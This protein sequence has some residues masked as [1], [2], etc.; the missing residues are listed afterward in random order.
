MY[1][2]HVI[3]YPGLTI[4]YQ[5]CCIFC[6][7][8]LRRRAD[9]QRSGALFYTSLYT[10]TGK[11]L[12][13][14]L[15][16]WANQQRHESLA[17]QGFRRFRGKITCTLRMC[18]PKIIFR[19]TRHR[20]PPSAIIVTNQTQARYNGGQQRQA[21]TKSFTQLSSRPNPFTSCLLPCDSGQ[22]MQSLI[23]NSTKC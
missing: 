18:G 8:F 22:I 6:R 2:V 7:P 4:A 20:S 13:F 19:R 15:L 11:F 3:V 23:D 1:P 21:S 9:N 12:W 5:A 16:S 14:R 17:Q 10:A